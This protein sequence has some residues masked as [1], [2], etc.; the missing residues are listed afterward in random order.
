M[1]TIIKNTVKSACIALFV[2]SSLTVFAKDRTEMITFTN[3]SMYA[4]TMK[5]SCD[6]GVV[7]ELGDQFSLEVGQSVTGRVSFLDKHSQCHFDANPNVLPQMVWFRMGVGY[8]D[9]RKNCMYNVID[10][11]C[12]IDGPRDATRFIIRNSL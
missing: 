1:N 10:V 4:F 6:E 5:A 12:G 8:G 2:L 9:L 7:N 3:E 11:E